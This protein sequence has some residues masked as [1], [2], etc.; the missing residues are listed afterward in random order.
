[1][2]LQG[3]C[4]PR[5][6]LDAPYGYSISSAIIQNRVNVQVPAGSPVTWKLRRHV[7]TA[8]MLND[9]NEQSKYDSKRHVDL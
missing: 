2:Q 8:I 9:R 5:D 7:P 4:V 6:T 1:M 3:T